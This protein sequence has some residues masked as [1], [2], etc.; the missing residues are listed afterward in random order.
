MTRKPFH[1]PVDLVLLTILPPTRSPWPAGSAAVEQ[2]EQRALQYAQDFIDDTATRLRAL[3]FKTK[4]T[5]VLG[6]PVVTILEEA[7]K[8]RPELIL[9]GSRGR[10]GVTRFVLGSVSHA[11]LH[12]TRCPDLRVNGGC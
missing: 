5:A 11:V 1:E 3:G 4:G 10:S 8:L 7:E 2:L 9:M 6:T 12:H